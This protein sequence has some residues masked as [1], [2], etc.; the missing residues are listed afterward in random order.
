[1]LCHTHV[2]LT[3]SYICGYLEELVWIVGV[4]TTHVSLYVWLVD[5]ITELESLLLVT[6]PQPTKEV[7][8]LIFAFILEIHIQTS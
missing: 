8:Q 7:E 1:M 6:L 3:Y 2:I 4:S 5:L